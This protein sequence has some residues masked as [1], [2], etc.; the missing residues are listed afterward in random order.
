MCYADVCVCALTGATLVGN[1][2][3]FAGFRAGILSKH[4]A[5]HSNLTCPPILALGHHFLLTY[6]NKLRPT[7]RG[8]STV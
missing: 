4:S 6:K 2:D 3:V 1:Q 7:F 5:C 8:S